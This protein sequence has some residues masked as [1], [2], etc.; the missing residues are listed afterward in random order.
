MSE[1]YKKLDL[2][3]PNIFSL[4]INELKNSFSL[5]SDNYIEYYIQSNINNENKVLVQRFKDLNINLKR[6]KNNIFF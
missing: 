5:L 3:K 2:K 4:K 6:L 1:Y